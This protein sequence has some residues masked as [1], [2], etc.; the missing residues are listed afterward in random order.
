MSGSCY[1]Q[2]PAIQLANIK[3]KVFKI[4]GKIHKREKNFQL[5]IITFTKYLYYTL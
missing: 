3:F 1:A 5:Q 4:E 2:K